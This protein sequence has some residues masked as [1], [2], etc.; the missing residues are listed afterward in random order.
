MKVG[1]DALI[2][3]SWAGGLQFSEAVQPERILDIGTGSGILALM[4]AQRF[5][6]AVVDAIELEP[7]AADQA[8]QNV[9][10]S[11]FAERITVHPRA[12]KAGRGRRTWWYATLPFFTTIPRVPIANATW[13]VTTT[14]YRFRRCSATSRDAS[15][16]EVNSLWSFLRT[17][18]K[19]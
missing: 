19:N 13:R 12:F 4:L 17:V 10:G 9:L 5:P 14:L 6:S 15:Q 8:N 7:D 11:P 1:T 3:G 16:I 2:L 18:R